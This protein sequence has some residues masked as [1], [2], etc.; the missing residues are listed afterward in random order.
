[1][2]VRSFDERAL[3]PAHEGTI[4]AQGVFAKEEIDAPFDGCAFGVLKPGMAQKPERVAVAK[5]YYVRCGEA[6]LRIEDEE[7]II[8][9]GDVSA[10][11]RTVTGLKTKSHAARFVLK[12]L[13]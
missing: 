5:L 4:L 6:T 7:R 12:L 1:M 9:E 8:R 2:L 11:L 13:Y 10:L 3:F